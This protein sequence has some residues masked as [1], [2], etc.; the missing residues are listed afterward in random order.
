MQHRTDWQVDAAVLK[1]HSRRCTCLEF[2]P[3]RDNLV[4]S[5]DK[6]GQAGTPCTAAVPSASRCLSAAAAMHSKLQFFPASSAAH[7]RP[8]LPLALDSEPNDLAVQTGQ[9]QMLVSAG[10]DMGLGEGI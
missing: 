9:G 1:L 10:G 4:L 6:K 8:G 7:P 2:H 5:G 3:L